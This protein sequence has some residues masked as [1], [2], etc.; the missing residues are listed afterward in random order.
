MSIFHLLCVEPPSTTVDIIIARLPE[1]SQRPISAPL[2]S[3]IRL[4]LQLALA[5]SATA[6]NDNVHLDDQHPTSW[7]V[8]QPPKTD[9]LFLK[10][11][12]H[13]ILYTPWGTRG[14]TRVASESRHVLAPHWRVP[15]LCLCGGP[16]IFARSPRHIAYLFRK[17]PRPTG[18]THK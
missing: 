5:D 4:A 3:L 9:R 16:R 12:I 1:A 17:I 8:S 11:L 18:G 2:L 6:V 13:F 15:T 7:A 10:I 14:F